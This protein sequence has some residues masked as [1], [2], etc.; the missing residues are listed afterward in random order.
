MARS[1]TARSS[2]HRNLDIRPGYAL[3][4]RPPRKTK[5]SSYVASDLSSELTASTSE[6]LG[7][8]GGGVDDAEE[9]Q[10]R[11]G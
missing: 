10:D 9:S 6:R 4:C 11:S 3:G 8:A 7:A 2:L 1:L 5:T